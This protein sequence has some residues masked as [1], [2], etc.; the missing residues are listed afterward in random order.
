[1]LQFFFH[2]V[3]TIAGC[4]WLTPAILAI[5]EADV[6]RTALR[7]QPGQIVWETLSQKSPSP[8]KGWWSGSRW[9]TW[10][11]TPVPPTPPKLTLLFHILSIT[12][13]E[14]SNAVQIMELFL[15]S[16]LFFF[17]SF[18]AFHC[19]HFSEITW[20]CV[21]VSFFRHCVWN[22]LE[23]PLQFWEICCNYFLQFLG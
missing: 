6:R 9:S 10:V 4:W 12:A 14:K 11:Q 22:S 7:S 2:K 20:W 18:N 16:A 19:F 21:L 3:L 23:T 13:F 8:K 1:V 15:L 5:Q 17:G